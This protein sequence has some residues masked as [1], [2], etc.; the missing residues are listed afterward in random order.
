VSDYFT[1]DPAEVIRFDR[2]DEE[3][4][5]FWLF[6]GCVA[7]KT[8]ATQARLLAGFLQSLP[9][10]IGAMKDTP[11]NRISTAWFDANNLMEKLIESRLGQYNRLARFMLESTHLDLRNCTVEDLEAIPGCGPKTARMFLMFSRPNQRFAALDT[12]VL[13]HL[14]ANGIQAPKTTPPAGKTYRRLELEFLKLADAS[15][16]CVA[17]YDLAV[18]KLYSGHAD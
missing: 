16:M 2:S 8:A 1:V 3:L 4:Q 18:W 9:V 7:G 10:P 13:K 5:T 17:D 15:G 11:F 12:H 6:C 14:R